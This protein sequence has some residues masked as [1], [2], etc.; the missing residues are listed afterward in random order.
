MK[1]MG[2]PLNEAARAKEQQEFA[3]AWNA[4]AILRAAE[5]ENMNMNLRLIAST[6]PYRSGW[7]EVMTDVH[8]GCVNF[9]MGD[10]DSENPDRNTTEIELTYSNVKALIAFL[11]SA[12]EQ[13]FPSMTPTLQEQENRHE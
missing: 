11:Q 7:L 3:D 12:C 10:C 13:A 9:E 8:K 1:E 5:I 2:L 6:V 4:I